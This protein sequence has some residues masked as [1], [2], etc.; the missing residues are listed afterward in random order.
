MDAGAIGIEGITVRQIH[1]NTA[2]AAVF[3]L[4]IGGSTGYGSQVKNG[5]LKN[6]PDRFGAFNLSAACVPS[7]HGAARS[8][9]GVCVPRPS[10]ALVPSSKQVPG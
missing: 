6:N 4:R 7:I 3:M 9:N 2:A 8:R 1:K 5:I 10:D